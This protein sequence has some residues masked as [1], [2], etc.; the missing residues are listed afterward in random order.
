MFVKKLSSSTSC[1]GRLHET[2]TARVD[3]AL[4][5]FFSKVAIHPFEFV[6]ERARLLPPGATHR[7]SAARLHIQT[8]RRHQQRLARVR[9]V[10]ES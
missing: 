5:G 7:Y 6:A 3:S 2:A 1:S 10:C 9:F 4:S 8:D